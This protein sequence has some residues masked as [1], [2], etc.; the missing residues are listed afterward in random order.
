MSTLKKKKNKKINIKGIEFLF[1][2]TYPQ[3]VMIK[4]TRTVAGLIYKLLLNYRNINVPI[5]SPNKYK[6]RKKNV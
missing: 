4:C 5:K 6:G 1:S 3:I 2:Q